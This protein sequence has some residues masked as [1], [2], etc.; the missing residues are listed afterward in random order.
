MVTHRFC[1][2]TSAFGKAVLCVILSSTLFFGA[3]FSA[4]AFFP[5]IRVR[6][7]HT[8]WLLSHASVTFTGDAG[9]KDEPEDDPYGANSMYNMGLAAK[10]IDGVT[11]GPG[12]IFS[13][14]QAVGPRTAAAGFRVG[15]SVIDD[16]FEPDEGGGV[17][18]ASTVLFQAVEKAGLPVVERHSHDIPIPGIAPGQDAAVWYGEED[19]RFENDTS[20][21]IRIAARMDGDTLAVALWAI[22]PPPTEKG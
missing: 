3:P 11:L 13:F 5:G 15:V 10:L 12:N 7:D 14:N 22:G 19:F 16:R 1:H 8:V 18:G 21:D 20:Y 17:C 9:A 4:A 2:G 6:G